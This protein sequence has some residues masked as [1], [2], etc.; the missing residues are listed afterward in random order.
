MSTLFD[1]TLLVIGFGLVIFVHELGHFAVAKWVG[2]RVEQFAIGM[3]PAFLAYRKGIGFRPKTTT[4]EYESRLRSN[5]DPRTMGETEYR[6]NILPIGGYVKM[7]GQDDTDMAHTD[8]HPRSYSA[9]PIWARMCVVSAGVIMNLIFAMVLFVI[10]FMWGIDTS[11]PIIGGV[12]SDSAAAVTWPRNAD[13]LDIDAPG[14]LPG[15]RVTAVNG[16]PITEF[17]QIASSAALTAPGKTLTIAVDRQGQQLQF[18]IEPRTD[19]TSDLRAIGAMAS[20][21]NVVADYGPAGQQQIEEILR[22][23]NLENLTLESGMILSHVDGEPVEA[24]WQLSSAIDNSDGRNIELTFTDPETN[25]TQQ[26]VIAT[27]PDLMLAQINRGED[28]WYPINHLFGLVPAPVVV[29]P[30]ANAENPNLPQTGDIITRL[31]SLRWPRSDQV[32]AKVLSS[33]SQTLNMTVWRDGEKVELDFKVNSRGI[34][35]FGLQSSGSDQPVIAH[36]L[37]PDESQI[38]SAHEEPRLSAHTLNLP[39]GT[40]INAI[41]QI[42]TPDWRSVHMALR[43]ALLEHDFTEDDQA[44]EVSIRYTLPWPPRDN[45][46]V[47]TSQWS[48]SQDDAR[49]LDTLGWHS[50]L[51]TFL[52]E[53]LTI[54]VRAETPWQAIAMGMDRTWEMLVATYQTLDRLIRGH[55]EVNQ[56][57]GPVGIAQL[58]TTVASH[59]LAQLLMF[60]GII[61]VNLAVLNFLPIPIVDGGL[62]VFLIV[63]KIKG[64]PVSVRVQNAATLAG[65]VLLGSIFLI[66]FYNDVLNLVYSITS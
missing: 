20:Q 2:I 52:F 53:P 34:V 35:P 50:Q 26:A 46:P 28:D 10:C 14:L 58:G 13:E 25:T 21:S 59:G 3:G 4:P 36:T 56:L 64:S 42:P 17:N 47:E 22:R 11:P 33:K 12:M 51:A 61:N 7:L 19:R 44:I 55:V 62:M 45:P 1:F 41:D 15:D 43:N 8:M 31:D 9:K 54:K 38:S 40:I 65:L 18:D 32:S 63:E 57:K 49:A 5:V 66:T 24:L 60:L 48:F 23:A 30:E 6:F 27:D 29:A 16:K 37:D 39:P